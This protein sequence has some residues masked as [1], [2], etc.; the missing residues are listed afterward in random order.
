MIEVVSNKRPKSD[1][2]LTESLVYAILTAVAF[3]VSIGLIIFPVHVTQ[4]C[5][6]IAFFEVLF[7]FFLLLFIRTVIEFYLQKK[8]EMKEKYEVSKEVLAERIKE[9]IRDLEK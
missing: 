4:S 6:A 7:M 3:G 2:F 8:Q 1:K 9:I 5:T